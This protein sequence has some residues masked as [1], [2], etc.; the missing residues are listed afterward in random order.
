[1][2]EFDNRQNSVNFT[3]E[4]EDLIQSSISFALQY[5]KFIKPH[6]MSVVI[7]DNKG[8]K[9]INNEFR[10]IDMETDVLSFPMLQYEPSEEKDFKLEFDDLNPETGEAVLGDIVLS[11]EK[12]LAQ[13]KEYDHSFER[14]VAFLIVHSVL[15][16]LGYDHE[17]DEDRKVMRQKEEAILDSMDMKRES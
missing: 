9:A 14:E 13:S 2:I 3:Q 1:M 12:A 17:K 6:E 15:H 11:L 8:I 16:L 10:S 4:L 7:T 5:E